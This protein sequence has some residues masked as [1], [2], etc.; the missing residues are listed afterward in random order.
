MTISG[1]EPA[2]PFSASTIALTIEIA[3]T[4]TA[5]TAVQTISSCV[6]PCVGGP[7]DSSSGLTLNFQTEYVSTLATTAKT[8]M[9]IAVVNQKTKWIRVASLP[10]AT[11]SHG[12]SSATAVAIAAATTPIAAS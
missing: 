5:G 2:L 8:P 10:A 3:V 6:W 12:T 4:R 11:G 1:F 7:S 9:Q